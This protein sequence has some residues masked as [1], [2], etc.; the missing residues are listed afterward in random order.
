M[1][2]LKFLNDWMRPDKNLNDACDLN[3]TT[4]LFPTNSNDFSYSHGFERFLLG[5]LLGRET[6]SHGLSL[7][8]CDKDTTPSAGCR[9]RINNNNI[10]IVCFIFSAS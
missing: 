2:P 5:Y 1:R 8:G 10:I 3:T 4:L 9:A 6:I 7:G